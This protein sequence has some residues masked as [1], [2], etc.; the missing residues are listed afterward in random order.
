MDGFEICDSRFKAFVLPNA[1]LEM[2]AEGFR[3][4]EG[5][6]W[7][8]DRDELLFSDLPNNRVMRWSEAGGLS[9]F[10]QPSNFE[11][12]HARDRQGRL[13]SCSHRGRCIT[14]TELDGSLTVL[15]D[16]YRGKRLNSPNDI[17]C[18]SDGTIWFTDPPYGIQTD[19]E[20]GKQESELPAAVYRLDPRDGS[21][22]IVADDFEG[23]NGLCFSPDES[24]LYVAESGLQFVP[25]PVQHIRVFGVGAD[26]LRD[27][28][29]FHTVTPGFA[30]GFRCDEEGHL[31]S[32]AAD[33]VHCIDP[34]GALL[35]KIRVPS[36][37]S[38][39]AFGGRNR[40]RLFLCASHTLYAIYVNRRGA[41]LL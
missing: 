25:D 40:S 13:L 6:V 27:G 15:A 19:Y 32:S 21:L 41:R 1:P 16:R 30:D 3:W 39:L 11:N 8:G 26:G 23:P 2:L 29:I 22:A 31:W 24:L 9:V 20:G 35:G 36:T 10:R 14:R 5:P 37:V 33:G 7:F 17:V 4:C 28:R 34:S 18:K 12:G 38:N